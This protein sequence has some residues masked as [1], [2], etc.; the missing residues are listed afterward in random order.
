M[1]ISF[2]VREIDNFEL[3]C[4]FPESNIKIIVSTEFGELKHKYFGKCDE[5]V[6]PSRAALPLVRISTNVES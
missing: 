3:N 4:T 6:Y 1:M 2:T 5:I